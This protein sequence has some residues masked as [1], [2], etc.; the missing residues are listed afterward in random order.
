MAT[1]QLSLTN[2]I[3]ISVSQAQSGVGEY[4]TSNL[5]LFTTETPDPVFDDG[6]KLYFSPQEVGEDFG[7]GSQTYQMANAVFSQKP[8]ILAGNGYL[9]VI[10]FELSETLDEAISRTSDLVQYFGIMSTQIESET[11]MLAAAAV[12]QA[13]NK[14]AFFVQ[15]DADTVEIGGSLDLLRS[16]SFTQSRGVFYGAATDSAALNLLAAYTG[17]ALSVNFSGSNTTF[18]MHLKDLLGVQPDPSMTQAL[19]A[20]CTAAGAD[21]YVSL[22][23]VSKVFCSGENSFFDQ[24]YNLQWLVGALQVAG[25][26]F[27]AQS[28]TKVPQT[29]GGM[30]GLKSAYRKVLEQAITNQYLAGGEWNSATTF[31]VQEDFLANITQRGYY[32]YSAPVA[33]QSQANREARQAPLIQ[34]ACK[35][36]GA[37]HSSSIIIYVNA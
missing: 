26:N 11:D 33:L 17:R 5:A 18:T 20:K 34:V 30:D 29:E 10:P 37:I 32:I 27:L 8:N 24:V 21:V 25:F 9:A 28:A 22:Q 31:G 19:L 23:G 13:L 1:N 3:N 16:G 4:N 12:V 35:E 36:A 7:T 14:I 2:V 6:Y 15:R